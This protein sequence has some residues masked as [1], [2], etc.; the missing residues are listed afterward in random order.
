MVIFIGRVFRTEAGKHRLHNLVTTLASVVACVQ[1]AVLI[2]MG[3][4]HEEWKRGDYTAFTSLVI[5]GELR[6][7]LGG[8]VE[9]MINRTEISSVE[10]SVSSHSTTREL[11]SLLQLGQVRGPNLADV[12]VKLITPFFVE[13][14]EDY[15]PWLKSTVSNDPTKWPGVWQFARVLRNAAVH[16]TINI[17]D[18]NFKPVSWY[19]YVYGPADHGRKIFKNDLPFAD[20]FF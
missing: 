20:I 4:K 1:T 9:D 5:D 11:R 16:N 7:P 3:S 8:V 13:F 15:L 12:N 18:V 14:Y 2:Q 6:M 10:L 19:Q 17:N